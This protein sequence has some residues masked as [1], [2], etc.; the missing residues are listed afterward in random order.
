[1]CDERQLSTT[2]SVVLN[3]VDV[4][5]SWTF[6]SGSPSAGCNVKQAKTLSVSLNPGANTLTAQ[7]TDSAGNVGSQ[8]VTYTYRPAIDTSPTNGGFAGPGMFDATLGYSIPSYTSLDEERSVS[9]FY[10]SGQAAPV[11]TVQIDVTDNSVD[12]AQRTSIKLLRN[13]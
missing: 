5:S 12:P 13:G 7:V 2:K 4:T 8:T 11:A 9:L 1:F 6:S 3:G 10:S